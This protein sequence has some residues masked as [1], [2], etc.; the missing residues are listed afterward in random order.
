MNSMNGISIIGTDSRLSFV[1]RSSSFVVGVSKG[2]EEDQEYVGRRGE[3]PKND[4][5]DEP[6]LLLL[7]LRSK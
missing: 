2:R 1:G 3:D 6:P 4:D 7:L 5:K